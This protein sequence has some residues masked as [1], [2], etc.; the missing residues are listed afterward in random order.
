MN[1]KIKTASLFFFSAIF[2]AYSM[3]DPKQPSSK[4][5]L[6]IYSD[7]TVRLLTELAY[8]EID[9]LASHAKSMPVENIKKA[10]KALYSISKFIHRIREDSNNVGCAF[11]SYH[12]GTSGYINLLTF[13]ETNATDSALK[14]YFAHSKN[15]LT[16]IRSLYE[17][18]CQLKAQEYIP[19]I[20]ELYKKAIKEYKWM[21][22]NKDNVYP[23]ILALLS[24]QYRECKSCLKKIDHDPFTILKYMSV[25]ELP[26][27]ADSK[28]VVQKL[29][30]NQQQAVIVKFWNAHYQIHTEAMQLY[31]KAKQEG[32]V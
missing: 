31:E 10:I 25:D 2:F 23:H 19:Q 6:L 9:F 22:Q 17:E 28:P 20:K 29:T 11:Q 32:L 12:Q 21:F 5:Q 8:F 26:N 1:Y 18:Y 24:L 30:S 3:E 14:D 13:L 7:R 16:R 27:A 4:P 15:I